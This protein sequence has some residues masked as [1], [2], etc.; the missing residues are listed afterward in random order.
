MKEC[1]CRADVPWALRTST[2]RSEGGVGA[3][4]PRTSR[5]SSSVRRAAPPSLHLSYIHPYF[6]RAFPSSSM[7]NLEHALPPKPKPSMGMTRG[8]GGT[9]LN[10][11]SFAQRWRS[12]PKRGGHPIPD[13]RGGF[14]RGGGLEAKGRVA[15]RREVQS[16]ARAVRDR[17]TGARWTM[18]EAWARMCTRARGAS[19]ARPPPI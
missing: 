9:R 2:S 8:G 15:V 4:P 5:T 11:S 18:A 3:P 7:S 1:I 19:A 6:Y 12:R 13:D 10:L 16:G 14:A 17:H